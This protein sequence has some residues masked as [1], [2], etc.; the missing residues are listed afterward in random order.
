MFKN[1]PLHVRV[2][3][4]LLK[5]KEIRERLS[6]ACQSLL[7]M[8]MMQKQKV[9]KKTPSKGRAVRLSMG[10]NLYYWFLFFFRNVKETFLREK[11]FVDNFHI[12]IIKYFVKNIRQ[13]K[14]HKQSHFEKISS[15]FLFFLSLLS[16]LFN[17]T[18]PRSMKNEERSSFTMF[19]IFFWLGVVG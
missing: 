18:N 15:I 16:S 1:S 13:R 12:N 6:V 17:K 3:H 5:R 10:W 7:W 11:F 19:R 2:T 4:F 9:K 8:T 14:V